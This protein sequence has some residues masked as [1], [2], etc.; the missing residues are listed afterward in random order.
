M[1]FHISKQN[2]LK[3]FENW[4]GRRVRII[5]LGPEYIDALVTNC[6]VTFIL[7]NRETKSKTKYK[8]IED[9]INNLNIPEE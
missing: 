6:S 8:S 7:T 9:A 2:I 5:D 1:D 3:E 4:K